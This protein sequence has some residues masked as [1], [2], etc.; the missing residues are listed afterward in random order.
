MAK[1]KAGTPAEIAV[2][3]DPSRG[4]KYE[5]TVE[6]I[7]RPE[8]CTHC[9]ACAAGCPAGAIDPETLEIDPALCVHCQRCSHV[10]QFNARTYAANRDGVDDKYFGRKPITYV[11]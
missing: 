7:Y 2:E 10:C 1:L 6:K 9:Q 8:N 3:G 4:E 11:V 5:S